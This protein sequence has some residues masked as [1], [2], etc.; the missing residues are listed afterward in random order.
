MPAIIISR[1]GTHKGIKLSKDALSQVD[2][3][4]AKAR[5][6]R[7]SIVGM[8]IGRANTYSPF[9]KLGE[10]ES[11]TVDEDSLGRPPKN[12]ERDWRSTAE[13]IRIWITNML[14]PVVDPNDISVGIT[15]DK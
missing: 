14:G 7:P 13:S 12:G 11:F 8:F 3:N 1:K 5:V 10:G 4:L 15:D 9:Y 6:H 2:A